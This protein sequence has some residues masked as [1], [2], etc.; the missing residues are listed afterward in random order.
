MFEYVRDVSGLSAGVCEG[1]PLVLFI[2]GEEGGCRLEATCKREGIGKELL[3]RNIVDDV[4]F[5]LV[6]YCVK[7]VGV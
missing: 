1:E 5:S 4:F 3:R 6:F 2:W 7:V